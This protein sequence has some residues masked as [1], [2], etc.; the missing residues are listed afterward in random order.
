MRIEPFGHRI[1]V[2]PTVSE[3]TK[4]EGGIVVDDDLSEGVVV[5]VSD[6]LVG[7]FMPGQHVLYHKD[8]GQSQY[9]QG[10]SCLW[11][12]TNTDIWGIVFPDKI[13]QDKGDSL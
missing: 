13:I 4:T 12:N 11:L 3:Y 10:K 5:E 7:K 2:S 6:E 1:I 9:Y 8:S